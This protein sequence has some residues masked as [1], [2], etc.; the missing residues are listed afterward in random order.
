MPERSRI[1]MNSKK[2]VRVLA[3]DDS[4]FFRKVLT[5]ILG[6]RDEIDLIG[7]AND[8]YDARDRLLAG[9]VDVMTLDLEL[10]RMGGL[11]F[12]KLIM[13]RKP[14][15]VIVLSSQAPP[16]SPKA[17]EALSAG[18]FAVMEKP[19]NHTEKKS[20]TQ[21]LV[22]GIKVAAAAPARAPKPREV[23]IPIQALSTSA[24]DSRQII[25]LGAST[26]GT[27]AL[28]HVLTSLPVDLPGIVVVQHIPAH[29][30][31]SFAA[32]LNQTCAM[33]VR[34]AQDGDAV[35]PG[36]ALIAPGGQHMEV[37]R[38]RGHY[39]VHL[40]EGP[41]VEHQRPSVDVLFKSLAECAGAHTVAALLTGMG[42]DGAAGMKELHNLH[43]HTIAQDAGSSVVYGMARQAVELKAINAIVPLENIAA[44][45]VKALEKSPTRNRVKS[46][47]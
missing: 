8:P 23:A 25:A 27:Q 12:L 4:A 11:T 13:D 39:R 6:R 22:S 38:A 35:R 36:L 45:I 21:K 7:C 24:Y 17:I 20:F 34:E 9:E 10:P 41:L 15:P 40:H 30:S 33:E 1:S 44:E 18:A 5:E 43:A 26:G 28:E 47:A 46:Y 14:M 31:A 32:R 29:F 37:R 16:G 3:V 42:R 19:K 2:A